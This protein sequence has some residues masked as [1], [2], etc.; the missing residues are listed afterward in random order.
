MTDLRF[1]TWN[2]KYGGHGTTGP[3]AKLLSMLPWDIAALQEVTPSSWE[4]L[5]SAGLT[6]GAASAF[7][8]DSPPEGH[9]RMGSAILSRN[10]HPLIDPIGIAGPKAGRGVAAHT[11]VEGLAVAVCSWH[12]PN[13]AGQGPEAKMSGYRALLDWTVHETLPMV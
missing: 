12:A 7:E 9:R 3:K 2:L 4:V 11:L 1:L 5:S 8:T 6:D 13:A 10:G